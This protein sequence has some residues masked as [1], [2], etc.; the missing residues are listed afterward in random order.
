MES[1]IQITGAAAY[2]ISFAVC[3]GHGTSRNRQGDR[4][5]GRHRQNP[6]IPGAGHGSTGNGPKGDAMNHHL[7]TE[8]ISSI[9]IGDASVYESRHAR[10]CA[11]CGGEVERMESALKIFRGAMAQIAAHEPE[12]FLAPVRWGSYRPRET[13]AA[14]SSLL[15]HGAALASIL[16]IGSIATT[17]PVLKEQVVKI[18]A[19]DL[20]PDKPERETAH[21]GGGGGDRSKIEAKQGALPKATARQFVPPSVDPPENAKLA[22]T[23]TIIADLP[24]INSSN[25]G[26]PSSQLGALSNGP[27]CCAGLGY[28]KGTGVGSGEGAGAGPGWGNGFGGNVFSI[29]GGV[30]APV[31]VSQV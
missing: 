9:V 12:R 23:P 22:M 5:Y 7:S 15:F 20:K 11:E 27:G 18:F 31:L 3:R 21:G 25:I 30:S 29:G 26:D 8:Q 10:E 19:P 1:V 6:F 28:G 17:N 2:G 4:A 14:L 13:A 16:V 24:A